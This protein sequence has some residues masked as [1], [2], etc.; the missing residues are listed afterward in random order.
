[1][2]GQL[3]SSKLSDTYN[4][5]TTDPSVS[6]RTYCSGI[7]LI[8]TRHKSYHPYL[9]KNKQR[10][11]EDEA[12]AAEAELAKEQKRVEKVCRVDTM[13]LPP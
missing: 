7:K 1:V 11:R 3:L 8:Q 9:E 10:V 4:A 12:K 6:L 2:S 5:S 13:P